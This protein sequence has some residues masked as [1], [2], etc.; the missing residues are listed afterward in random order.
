VELSVADVSAAAQ[1]CEAT[2]AEEFVA[3]WLKK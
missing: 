3:T 1:V 2:T